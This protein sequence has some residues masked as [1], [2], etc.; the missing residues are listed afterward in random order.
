MRFTS[1]MDL[2]LNEAQRAAS[3]GEV[4][5]GAVIVDARGQVLAAAGNRTRRDCD[6]T[7]HAEILAIRQAAA[8]LGQERLAGCTLYVTLEP[9]AMCAGALVHARVARVVYGAADPKSG[10]TDHGAR[11]FTHPQSHHRPEVIGGIS[12]EACSTLL[13]DFFAQQRSKA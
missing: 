2:A 4:P 7:A 5:V 11:V 3:A 1:Q 8:I 6:P 10:G 12:D 9:C 13:V